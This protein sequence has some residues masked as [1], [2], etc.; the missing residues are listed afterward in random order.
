MRRWRVDIRDAPSPGVRTPWLRLAD[1]S[2][3]PPRS[4]VR[5]LL[6]IPSA[7]LIGLAAAYLMGLRI[8]LS[9]S[10]PLGVY[11]VERGPVSRG[12]TVLVCLSPATAAIARARGYLPRGV[13]DDGSAP[14]G[15]PVIA[16]DGD[17]IT[18]RPD[19]ITVNGRV[20][21]N[22]RPLTRDSLG[23]VLLSYPLGQYLV[24]PDDIWIV[25]SYS[26]RSF[27]SRYFGP[28][29]VNRVLARIRRICCS[30]PD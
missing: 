16:I 13:C 9:G 7:V 25:S 12:S 28:V 1:T 21:P 17:T 27:D 11:R 20:V 4:V 15:K 26:S 3:S 8:N 30:I 18:V 24:G 6:T 5:S 2:H 10:I 29:P 23:R 19:A 22:S 14:L